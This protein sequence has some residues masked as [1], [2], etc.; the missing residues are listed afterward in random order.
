VSG[1]VV[2][3][4]ARLT[5]KPYE[6]IYDV[7]CNADA[8]AVE[9]VPI[10][11][12]PDDDG[13]GLWQINARLEVFTAGTAGT[14]TVTIDDTGFGDP[15]VLTHAVN[16]TGVAKITAPLRATD[17]VLT[18]TVTGITTPGTLAARLNVHAQYLG[19]IA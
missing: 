3:G 1:S 11:T 16:S 12:P 8:A 15:V 5:F 9:L 14:I 6:A 18:V 7:D 13:Q 19:P 17:G 10:G 4:R 2:N